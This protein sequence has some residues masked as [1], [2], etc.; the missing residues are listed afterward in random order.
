MATDINILI[1]ATDQA[2]PALKKVEGELKDVGTQ[3]KSSSSALSG[4]GNVMK[5]GLTTALIGTAAAVGGLVFAFKDSLGAAKESIEA[6]KQLEQ[7][8]KSTGGAAGVTA[9]QANDLAGSLA[10]MTNFQDDAIISGENLLL[11]FTGIGKDVFPRATE[12]M[13]DMSQALGQD[14]SSSA[15]QLGKAL[16][17]P[18]NGMT[19]LSRVGVSFTDSQK[20][21]ITTMQNANDIAGAQG[22]IL[23]EL[24]KEFGGSA[25]A[26]ADPATQLAN[27]WGEVEEAVGMGLMPVLANLAQTVLPYVQAAANAV[28]TAVQNFYKYLGDGMPVL[29][30][31]QQAIAD[32][33]PDD[34]KT[35]WNDFA[36]GIQ[37]TINTVTGIIQTNAGWWR[38]AWEVN[39]GGMRTSAEDFMTLDQDFTRFWVRVNAAF[40]QGETQ[41]STDWATW[42][43][44]TLGVFT[45]WV[46]FA[47]DTLGIFFDN[48]GRTQRAWHALTQGDWTTFWT[49]LGG[50]FEGAMNVILNFVEFVFGPNLRNYFVKGM[51]DAWDGMKQTWNDIQNWWNSTIGALFG[52]TVAITP[53]F[54]VVNPANTGGGASA[55]AASGTVN[56]IVVNTTGGY[57]NGV[58][59]GDG[60][61]D[62]LRFRGH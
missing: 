27:A 44:N 26:L 58:A 51:T 49:T 14:L 12:T 23:D 22:V 21:M 34:W 17:D 16:N 20:E 54:A 2:S 33:L 59:A 10:N 30:A 48:W 15:V 4:I 62:A 19:A 9:E 40:T 32:V 45:N 55:S 38:L 3:A 42:L 43:G 6:H 61:V 53:S 56:N 1:K 28:G 41:N 13:L 18:I 24:A 50:N 60:I 25:K 46:R 29:E 57:D 52:Q 7:V 5:A 47:L 39:L 11:T 37:G 31:V 35:K 36:N 8:I